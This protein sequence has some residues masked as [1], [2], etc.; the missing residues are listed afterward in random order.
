M[1]T[2][3]CNIYEVIDSAWVKQPENMPDE[4]KAKLARIIIE[5]IG[6][7]FSLWTKFK[8]KIVL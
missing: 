1:C 7:E 3:Y 6:R 8:A 2:L 4:G 5:I